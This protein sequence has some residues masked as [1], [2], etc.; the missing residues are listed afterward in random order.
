M[1]PQVLRLAAAA[2]EDPKTKVDDPAKSLNM[3]RVSLYR[4]LN[5]DGS[6]KEHGQRLLDRAG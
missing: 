2:L 1:T 6:L 5:G 3:S 4:Y